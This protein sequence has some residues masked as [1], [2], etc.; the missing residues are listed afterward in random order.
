MFNGT[1][2]PEDLNAKGYN[3]SAF[4]TM[5][6]PAATDPIVAAAVTY[7]RD[8]LGVKR[9]GV[10]GYCFGGRYALRA[11]GGKKG[12]DVAFAAHPSLW[13]SQDVLAVKG[14]VSIAEAG[15]C[16]SVLCSVPVLAY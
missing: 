10:T 13:T 12:A 2:A 15:E 16:P 1:P 3:G 11:V 9:I 14:P 4:L 6:D 8:T 7:L 5:H